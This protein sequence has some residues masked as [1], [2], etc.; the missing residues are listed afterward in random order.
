M[1]WTCHKNA[2]SDETGADRCTLVRSS[3][4]GIVL[5]LDSDLFWF[6]IVW[7]CFKRKFEPHYVLCLGFWSYTCAERISSM[8]I[9]EVDSVWV[10]ITYRGEAERGRGV[11]V[12]GCGGGELVTYTGTA[13]L[14]WCVVARLA[15]GAWIAI[16]IL[17]KWSIIIFNKRIVL[18]IGLPVAVF[19]I[20]S[21]TSTLFILRRHHAQQK[22]MRKHETTQYTLMWANQRRTSMAV[23]LTSD[24]LWSYS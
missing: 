12:R 22:R 10:K 24:A 11:D 8:A 17:K 16:E 15:T 13:E 7:F 19:I 5:C 1:R 20:P 4:H 18:L 6:F 14:A 23:S 21:V 3:L 9:N 2:A